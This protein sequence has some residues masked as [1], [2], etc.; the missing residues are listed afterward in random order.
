[1]YPHDNIF[2]IYYE[3]GKR[4]PFQVKRSP[5]GLNGSRDEEYR[6]S[7]EGITYMVERVVPKGKYGYAFGY[8]MKDGIRDDKLHIQYNYGKANGAIPNAG[9]GEWCLIDIP[10]MPKEE[11]EKHQNAKDF[12]HDTYKRNGDPH[13]TLKIVEL[14]DALPFG[15]YKGKTLREVLE[16]DKSYIDWVITNVKEYQLKLS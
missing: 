11:V 4:V 14:D 16:T 15:K 3:I 1:M 12:C 10:Q 8:L 2:N 5:I 9:C 13:P 6:Y 7:Q